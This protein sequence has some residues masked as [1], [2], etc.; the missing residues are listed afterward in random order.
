MSGLFHPRRRL[1]AAVPLCSLLLLGVALPLTAQ[2]K[3]DSVQR[4]PDIGVALK[5]RT[6]DGDTAAIPLLQKLTL[7]TTS[8][9]TAAQAERTVNALDAQDVLKY[10]PSIFLRKRNYGDNQAT[11]Q[12]RVW[13]VSSSAR[14]LVFADGVPLSALIG[15]NNTIGAPRWGLIS[16]QE[17]ARVD[18]MQGP[19][20]AAYAGNS[21]GG[22]I[23]ISTRLPERLEASLSQTFASQSFDLYGTSRNYGTLQT[24]ANV[25]NRYGRFAFW[26]SGN[27]Q[28]S[29]SQPLAYVTSGSFPAGTTGGIAERNKLGATAN[30]LGATGLLQTDM[31]NGKVKLAYD[32]TPTLRAAYTF[33][34]W[35]NS[36]ES[37][38]ESYLRTAAGAATYAGQSGFATGS[39]RLS[40]WH[41]SHS[42]AVRT[43]SRGA[44]NGEVIAT[45][46]RFDTD[47]QRSPSTA[48][49]NGTS[50]GAAGRL[51]L[52]DG[53]GWTTLD[54]KGAWQ[55]GGAEALH[56]V[57]A[58]LHYDAY[59][60][61]NP[62]YNVADWTT[63][64]AASA[65]SLATR[66]DGKTRTQAVWVQDRV[67]LTPT[68]ALTVGGRYE[69]WRAYDGV[70]TNG[71]TT[72][73]QAEVSEA[74]FSPKASLRW[75][76]ESPWSVTA[77]LAQAYRF[78]TA[79]ELYQLVTTGQTFT[80]PAP[81]LKPDNA[82]SA[83]VRIA[84]QF[85]RT[86]VQLA[87]FQDDIHDA[88]I[89]QFQPLVPNSSTLYS[90]LSNVD[91]VR[92]R[93]VE[94][95]VTRAAALLPKLDLSASV[96]YVDAKT[97]A[98]S[99]RASATAPVGTAIGKR[100]PNLPDWRA[101]ATA[102][103]R[104]T[105]R[106]SLAVAGRYSGDIYTTLD[107]A[108]VNPNTYQGFSSWFVADAKATYRLD[109]HLTAALGVD[110]LNNRKYFLFHPFPQRTLVGSLQYGL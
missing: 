59:A 19:Y 23:E 14:S 29:N 64:T 79:T 89:A 101:T 100:V 103:Y 75:A 50:V 106:L 53:T 87:L 38:V 40:A 37:G 46:Y 32:L 30:I 102:T 96:T 18:V 13:G 105:D 107:N 90:Y 76:P 80:S 15:N 21:L 22:V 97:L 27:Y 56:T 33:G 9:I 3:R 93:G 41:T 73:R 63:G 42:L 88:I 48:V 91:H 57:T 35:N 85:D 71:A 10:L 86:L 81:D 44:W 72:V 31:T 99:G 5:R 51:S 98:L 104:A 55:R 2:V 24:A 95:A 7:P 62:S 12:T 68:L 28:R 70:N 1:R 52:F 34:I 92:A 25:G 84:G 69:G 39:N 66:G 11:V 60:L 110:N 109:G 6:T 49:A 17:I 47:Q 36:S 67:R 82:V 54:V 16:P 77:S 8:S 45:R 65:T 94:L 58:G 108:D 26:A 78:P 20:S 83:E 74:R 43:A 61:V 4:L